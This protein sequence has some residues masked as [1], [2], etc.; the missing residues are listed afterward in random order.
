MLRCMG[1]AAVRLLGIAAVLATSSCASGRERAA[2]P[3]DW[4]TLVTEAD[5]TRIRTWR[6]SFVKA[7]TMARTSGHAD[8]ID[9]Q[10]QLLRPDAALGDPPPPPGDYRCRVVRLGATAPGQPDFAVTPA[11]ACRIAAAD[12]RL[13]LA[14]MEGAQRPGGTL[15][16]D[17]N[18]RMIFLGTMRMADE[19]RSL[20]YGRDLGRNMAGILERIGPQ[21]WRLVL[22]FPQWG[23]TLEVVELAPA[24]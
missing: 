18:M 17:G 1:R 22:P 11:E 16:V 3:A 19:P 8:A 7:L 21:R 10:G 23:S 13:A 15:Y 20:D 9:A 14:K 5:R 24:G 2:P 6:D 4:R 12:G